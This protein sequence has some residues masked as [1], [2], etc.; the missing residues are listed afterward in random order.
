MQAQQEEMTAQQNMLHEQL[1]QEQ[2]QQQEQ[3]QVGYVYVYLDVDMSVIT[4][5]KILSRDKP[6]TL[7]HASTSNTQSFEPSL[8]WIS[9]TYCM[10]SYVYSILAN[11]VCSLI[12]IL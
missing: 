10:L 5:L 6:I 8:S 4:I 7:Y 12:Y 2:K 1:L 11:S 9:I 3:Q